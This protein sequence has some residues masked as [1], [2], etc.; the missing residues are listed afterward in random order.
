MRSS[1]CFAADGHTAKMER[2]SE[3]RNQTAIR[4]SGQSWT[5]LP[6]TLRLD[7]V[8]SVMFASEALVQGLPRVR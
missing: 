1:P 5:A 2:I 4:R 7:I 3:Q 8:V 6:R